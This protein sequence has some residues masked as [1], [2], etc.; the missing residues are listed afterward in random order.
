MSHRLSR[1][2]ERQHEISSSMGFEVPEP[3]VYPPL[4]PPTV[5]DPWAWYRNAEGNDED[6]DDDDEI[7]EESE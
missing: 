1:L 6:D 5:E 4:P 3:V 2:E 7:E